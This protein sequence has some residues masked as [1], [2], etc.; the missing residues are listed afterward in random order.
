MIGHINVSVSGG[1]VTIDMP[2]LTAAG[3]TYTPQLTP[4]APGV[5]LLMVDGTY[6]DATLVPDGTGAYDTIRTRFAVAQRVTGKGPA[7]AVDAARLRAALRA[8]TLD[9][10]SP[11]R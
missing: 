8:P 7:V 2:D 10:P 3:V 4:M 9:R 11:A 1:V 6:L 5:F